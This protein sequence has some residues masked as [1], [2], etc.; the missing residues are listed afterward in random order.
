MT[1]IEAA[2]FC[3]KVYVMADGKH[4]TAGIIPGII[5]YNDVRHDAIAVDA[6]ALLKFD[7]AGPRNLDVSIAATSGGTIAKN[8]L[9]VHVQ[10]ARFAMH[11]VIGNVHLPLKDGETYVLSCKVDG[12]EW[13]PA[14]KLDMLVSF[15]EETRPVL[16]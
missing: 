12:E 1:S 3:E 11:L 2:F 10:D 14:C 13:K 8:S 4:M 15:V 6:Y 9:A 7:R 5:S 16:S